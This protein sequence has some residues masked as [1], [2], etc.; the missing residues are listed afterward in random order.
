MKLSAWIHADL[1]ACSC[2]WLSSCD[3]SQPHSFGTVNLSSP[4]LL[5]RVYMEII[6]CTDSPEGHSLLCCLLSWSNIA[7]L[8]MRGAPADCWMTMWWRTK[9]CWENV[10]DY[11]RDP[12]AKIDWQGINVGITVVWIWHWC[13]LDT[14][15]TSP[16]L[17]LTCAH[18]RWLDHGAMLIVC[19]WLW[20][21]N[22]LLC[23]CVIEFSALQAHWHQNFPLW[24]SCQNNTHINRGGISWHGSD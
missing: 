12:S 21:I 13:G 1:I 18:S 9:G 22:D 7:S 19:G 14:V 17:F 3:C 8:W 11:I 15:S 24:V 23:V 20:G 10:T 4:S 6:L 16:F 5:N 2:S